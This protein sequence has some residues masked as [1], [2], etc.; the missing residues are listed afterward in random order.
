MFFDFPGPAQLY[1][2]FHDPNN[3]A[4][5]LAKNLPGEGTLGPTH[6][7]KNPGIAGTATMPDQD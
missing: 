7:R 3:L 6:Y 1:M 2:E 4:K 5:H